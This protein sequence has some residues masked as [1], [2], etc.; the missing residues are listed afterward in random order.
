MLKINKND[1]A[2]V[3]SENLMLRTVESGIYSV[4]PDNE[5]GS[6]Y[7]TQFGFFMTG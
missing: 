4:F 3:L 2:A 6:E 1:L 7:D 5:S